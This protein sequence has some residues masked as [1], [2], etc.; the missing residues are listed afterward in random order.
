MV[1]NGDVSTDAR[2]NGAG[3]AGIEVRSVARRHAIAWAAI[4]IGAL[5]ILRFAKGAGGP[6]YGVDASYYYQLARHVA[7]GEGLVTTVSL[8][9]E[10]WV[11]PAKT[12]I[13]PLWPLVMGYVGRWVGLVH[14]ADLLPRIFYVVGLVLLYLIARAVAVRVGGLRLSR[15]GWM[16][17]TAHWL[18]A[19]FGLAPR[20][21]GATTHPYTEGLAFAMGFASFLALERFD[22][23]RTVW[24]AGTSGLFA[25]LAFLARTQMV[26]VA[27]GC[28]LALAWFALRDRSAR[29]GAVVWS[30]AAL[31]TIAPWFLFLGFLPGLTASPLPRADIPPLAGWTQHATASAWLSARAQS[32][33][34]MFDPFDASSYVQS[35]GVVVYLV[36]IAAV[37]VLLELARRRSVRQPQSIFRTAMFVAGVFFFFNLTLYQS[38]VWLP[39]LFGWR[40]GLPFIL[41]IVLAVTWLVARA[42]RAAPAIAIVLLLS[43]VMSG[44]EVVAFVRAPDVQLTPAETELVAWLNAQPRPLSVISSNAQILGSMSETRF[45]WTTCDSPGETTRAMIRHMPIE[46]VLLYE[47]ETRCA[48]AVQAGAMR[49]VRMFGAPGRRIFVLQPLR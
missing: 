36:P 34:I 46:Y 38:D 4:I 47:R 45:Y 21:F 5:T 29:A 10:G 24:A 18:V 2:P 6:P 3:P 26:G 14:A 44:R 49:L 28:F 40:H 48:F 31:A 12:P 19:I 25:G 32:L 9:H 30:L 17:D 39:W 16:P 35:F 13:Y 1:K 22:R 37:A 8:Y 23:T 27:I 15:S 11:L 43:V 33:A 20:Y 41:L 7:N 42:G